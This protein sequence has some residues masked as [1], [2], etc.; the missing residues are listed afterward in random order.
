MGEAVILSDSAEPVQ[1]ILQALDYHENAAAMVSALGMFRTRTS[2]SLHMLPYT[3]LMP[4]LSQGDLHSN[5]VMGQLHYFGA[6]H[7]SGQGM[8]CW[9]ACRGVGWGM[10]CTGVIAA[11]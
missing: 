11:L 9:G 8:L 4:S 6:P 3:L 10:A 5:M 1:Q 2:H 7:A